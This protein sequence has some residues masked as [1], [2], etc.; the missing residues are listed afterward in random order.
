LMGD[1][2]VDLAITATG[3]VKRDECEGYHHQDDDSKSV[4]EKT[5]WMVHYRVISLESGVPGP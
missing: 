2:E 1:L 3:R 5:S 4:D